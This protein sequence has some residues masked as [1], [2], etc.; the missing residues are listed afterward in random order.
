MNLNQI[1]ENVLKEAGS[2]SLQQ[3][4]SNPENS[5]EAIKDLQESLKLVPQIVA[6]LSEGNEVSFGEDRY[7]EKTIRPKANGRAVAFASGSG[8]GYGDKEFRTR[9]SIS[10]KSITNYIISIF[11]PFY[12]PTQIE[13]QGVMKIFRIRP[14]QKGHGSNQQIT[15]Q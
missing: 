13:T 1:F 7:N 15:L 8:Y 6:A 9:L 11:S 4:L 10:E 2:N 5:P 3:I 12:D 14:V